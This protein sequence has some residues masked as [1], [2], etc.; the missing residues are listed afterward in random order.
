MHNEIPKIS[1][2]LLY[3]NFVLD[4]ASNLLKKSDQDAVREKKVKKEQEK[5]V[6][7]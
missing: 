6:K 7:K 5:G 1:E 2:L 4:K 3:I